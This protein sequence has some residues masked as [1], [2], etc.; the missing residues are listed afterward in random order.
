MARRRGG[1]GR[2]ERTKSPASGG[3]VHRRAQRSGAPGA[4]QRAGLHPVAAGLQG[5]DAP[6]HPGAEAN[7]AAHPKRGDNRRAATGGPTGAA[8]K[9]RAKCQRSCRHCRRDGTAGSAEAQRKESAVRPSR[10][11]TP[12][13]DH[14]NIV[15]SPREAQDNPGTLTAPSNH[16][17]RTERAQSRSGDC[18]PRSEGTDHRQTDRT[19]HGYETTRQPSHSWLD[20]SEDTDQA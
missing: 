2:Q 10:P 9:G 6:R 3:G 15:T 12:E 20:R 14:S 19:R 7:A 1:G 4:A 5:R 16:W 11:E 17:P 13:L 8:S 18:K